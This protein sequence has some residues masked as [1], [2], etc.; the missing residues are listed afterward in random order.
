[1]NNIYFDFQD[2]K[3]CVQDVKYNDYYEEG[4]HRIRINYTLINLATGEEISPSNRIWDNNDFC[5]A[6]DYATQELV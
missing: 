1:M 5:L 4:C 3:Y 6:F 2:T